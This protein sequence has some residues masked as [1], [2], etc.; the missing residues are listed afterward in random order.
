MAITGLTRLSSINPPPIF[1]AN[2]SNWQA[3]EVLS[4]NVT[5]DT[6][7]IPDSVQYVTIGI[8]ITGV[9]SGRIEFST[10]SIQDIMA[11]AG[12]WDSWPS[13]NVAVNTRDAVQNIT[14]IRPVKVSG[15]GTVTLE[16]VG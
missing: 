3:K 10:S 4:A 15:A 13:G 7:I 5:G 2:E 6:Y 1:Y 8:I 16:V 9:A 11:G 14:A 12:V